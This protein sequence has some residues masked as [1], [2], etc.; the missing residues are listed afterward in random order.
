MLLLEIKEAA[1]KFE[2]YEVV[3]VFFGGG[4]PSVLAAEDTVKIAAQLKRFFR[5][6]PNAEI[7]TEVNPGTVHREKLYAYK[8]CGFNRLSIG[9]QSAEEKELKALGRIHDYTQFLETFYTAREL[10]FYN[11][12]VDLMSAIPGQTLASYENTLKKLLALAPE[13]ISAYSLIVEEGTPFFDW[14]GE[15]G[16]SDRGQLCRA[17]DGKKIEKLPEEETEREMYELTERLLLQQGYSRYEISNYAKQ[18]FACVHNK[19]YWTRQEYLGFGIGAASLIG[20]ERF[21]NKSSLSGYLTGDFSKEECLHLSRED[22]M[23]EF[24]FLGLRLTAGVEKQEFE[25]QFGVSMEEVYGGVLDKMKEQ[26]LL[27]EKKGRIYLSKRGLD[28]SNYVMAEFLL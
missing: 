18:G 8:E 27:C 22:C 19:A 24:M 11:V 28:V 17:V 21:R 9:L 6:L 12:N 1:W 16:K 26:E 7:T 23:E 5:I 13:H 4:T 20:K 2:D 15:D 10:G 3:S 14:Y 25:K